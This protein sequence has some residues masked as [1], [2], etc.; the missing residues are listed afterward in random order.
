MGSPPEFQPLEEAEVRRELELDWIDAHGEPG[1]AVI[2]P[3]ILHRPST[4][5]D[6]VS[7]VNLAHYPKLVGE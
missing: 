7:E 1:E 4:H 3:V 2:Y 5:A 6:A